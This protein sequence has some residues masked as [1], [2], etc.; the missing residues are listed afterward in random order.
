MR[1]GL[2]STASI[3]RAIVRNRDATGIELVAVASRDLERAQAFAREHAIDRA[4]GSYEA[5]LA[6]DDVDAVY[7]A[8]PNTLHVEWS[9]RALEA[10]KHVL[11]EKPLTRVPEEAERAFDAADRAGRVLMEGFMY[12][13]HPQTRKLQELLAAGAI[14]RLRAIHAAFTFAMGAEDNVRFDATLGG[15]ALLDVG[16]YCVSGSRLLAGEPHTVSA[17]R[18]L[19][20]TGVDVSFFGTMRFDDDVVAQFRSSLAVPWHQ[21]LEAVGDEGTAV[22]EI[23]WNP[24]PP[25]R[26]LLNGEAIEVEEVDHFRLE[27]ENFAEAAAGRAEPLVTRA[28]SLGQARTLHA[29][30]RAAESGAPV[31]L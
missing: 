25:A 4:H 14:G 1:L 2:L 5:L 24:R 20:P 30:I 21:R 27:L 19:G 18:V 17:E 23:P 22:V 11:C 12:R 8:L 6:D 26:V 15:G 29:L 16:C 10:G 13:H 3:G 31:R 9:V 7:V 28:D